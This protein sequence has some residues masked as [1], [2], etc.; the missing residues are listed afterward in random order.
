MG[1]VPFREVCHRHRHRVLAIAPHCRRGRPLRATTVAQVRLIG[2]PLLRS[3]CLLV[4]VRGSTRVL[5]SVVRLCSAPLRA[6][7]F[8]QCDGRHKRK[9][10]VMTHER[11][12]TVHAGRPRARG[13]ARRGRR[14]VHRHARVDFRAA[15]ARPG[16]KASIFGLPIESPVVIGFVVVLSL[17]LAAALWFRPRALWILLVAVGF[18]L[19]TGAFDVREIP[20]QAARANLLLVGL[21]LAAGVL[22][23]ATAASAGVAARQLITRRARAQVTPLQEGQRAA[24]R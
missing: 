16:P 19:V 14:S 24:A 17:L 6:E 9:L 3:Q 8:R 23:V 12:P 2:W 1:I 21:A 7:S 22:H 5:E 15:D 20:F 10:R 4:I 13:D 18:A 11:S